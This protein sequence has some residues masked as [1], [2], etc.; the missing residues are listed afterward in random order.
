MKNT[1]NHFILA[2]VLSVT[3]FYNSKSFGSSIEQPAFSG[4]VRLSPCVGQNHL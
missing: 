3:L 2:V 1:T 4:I